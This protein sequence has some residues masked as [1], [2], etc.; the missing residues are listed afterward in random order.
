MCVLSPLSSFFSDRMLYG[1]PGSQHRLQQKCV[2]HLEITM[3]AWLSHPLH[4][5]FN[6]P[7]LMMRLCRFLVRSLAIPAT[8]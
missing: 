2:L 5:L 1:Y 6:A 3:E 8:S 7:H 4:Q